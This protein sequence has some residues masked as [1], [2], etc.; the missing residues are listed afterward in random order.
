MNSKVSIIILNWNGWEDTI[1]CLESLYRIKYHNYDVIVIDNNSEDDSVKMIKEYAKGCLEVNSKFFSYN[2]DNKPIK[3]FEYK[4]EDRKKVEENYFEIPSD[5]K[6]ILIKNDYNYGFAEGN[7][8]GIKFILNNLNP[9]YVLLL[10]NDTIV[11]KE[12]LNKSLEVAGS[13]NCGIVGSKTYLYDQP[14]RLQFAWTKL[15]LWRG[16]CYMVGALELDQGL[17]DKIAIADY[18]SGSTFLIKKEVI[19][20][21]GFLDKKYFCYWEDTDYCIRASKAGYDLKYCPESRIWHKVSKSSEC[22]SGFEIY[23]MTRNMF[24]F[25][26]KHCSK[27]QYLSFLLYFFLFKFWYKNNYYLYHKEINLI[28]C[29]LNGLKDGL[30]N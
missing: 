25:M 28:R 9:D 4:K 23:L 24:I 21:I 16:E 11:D 12:F 20:N 1:E 2:H 15:N 6:M 30:K 3:V 26:K 13:K 18:I 27:P 8:I 14:E 22:I 5:E 10:N 17:Y 7:N 19:L 29:Y